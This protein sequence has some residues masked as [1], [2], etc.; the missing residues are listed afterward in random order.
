MITYL[1]S[2]YSHYII[3]YFISHYWESG[4][5]QT[6]CTLT[7][8]HREG[9][10]GTPKSPSEATLKGTDSAPALRNAMSKILILASNYSKGCSNSCIFS[11]LCNFILIQ[12]AGIH[13]KRTKIIHGNGMNYFTINE[14]QKDLFYFNLSSDATHP[15]VWTSC[16]IGFD[17]Q[18]TWPLHK[19]YCYTMFF[20]I[21]PE[22]EHIVW[23]GSLFPFLHA[24]HIPVLT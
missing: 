4:A 9:R 18:F 12:Y 13:L 2:S 7:A 6:S 21:H 24:Y 17:K 23:I 3:N 11:F 16:F 15:R 1:S 22:W 10:T 20:S 19:Y 14:K 8:A 5:W